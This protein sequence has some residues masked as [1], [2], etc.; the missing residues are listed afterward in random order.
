M[1]NPVHWAWDDRGM[2]ATQMDIRQPSQLVAVAEHSADAG[3]IIRVIGTDSTNRELRSQTKEGIGLDGILVPIHAQ[4]DFPYG[5]IAPDGVTIVTRST[6]T[7]PFVDFFTVN[8]EAHQFISGVQAVLTHIGTIPSGLTDKQKYYIGAIVDN[9][10]SSTTIRLYNT[11]IDAKTA[12]NPI[13]MQS[14]LDSITITLTDKRPI[15]MVTAVS[16]PGGIPPIEIA[17]ANQV[18]FARRDGSNI[19]TMLIYAVGD[20][21]SLLES[22]VANFE[23]GSSSVNL[24][25]YPLEVYPGWGPSEIKINL[26]GSVNNNTEVSGFSATSSS[27]SSFD[28][29]VDLIG[30]EAN[31]IV[32]LTFVT[33]APGFDLRWQKVES[34]LLP[35]P[36]EE[37]VAYFV[38]Q[39]DS[40]SVNDVALKVY[41][42]LNDAQSDINEIT[43]TGTNGSTNIFIRK[44]LSPQTK[45]VFSADPGYATGDTVTASTNGG[46]L[47]Q[48]LIAG[49]N[50]Y[51]SV[52]DETPV[53][54]MLHE[55]Y[56]DA[57]AGLNPISLTT[58]GT[59]QNSIAR[60]LPATASSG[61]R[62]NISVSGLNLPSASG[63]GAVVIPQVT[64]P[65]TTM[66]IVATGGGYSS[67]TCT[68]SDVGGYKY[69][70]TPTVLLQNGSYIV[71]ATIN[72][73]IATDPG[74][75][76]GYVSSL[77]VADGGQGYD[78]SNPPTVV[79]SGGL[80]SGGFV[81]NASVTIGR[82]I[83]KG[84]YNSLTLGQ[85]L[86][87][88]QQLVFS[89]TIV[90]GSG[91]M[92]YITTPSVSNP[93][94]GNTITSGTVSGGTGTLTFSSAH[95]LNS[96]DSIT[97]S[98]FTPA[99]WNT[100]FFVLSVVS[101]TQITVSSAALGA[102][103]GYG[104]YTFAKFSQYQIVR[105]GS[106]Y[107]APSI[108]GVLLNPN[109]IQ[110]SGVTGTV[111]ISSIKVFS[112]G[113]TIGTELLA[114]SLT[115][116]TTAAGATTAI[117]NA[118]NA[119]TSNSRFHATSSG[120]T[121]YATPCLSLNITSVGNVGSNISSLTYTTVANSGANSGAVSSPIELFA[122]PYVL[123]A[124]DSTPAAL[125]TSIAAKINANTVATQFSAV[126]VG[127]LVLIKPTFNVFCNSLVMTTNGSTTYF[128]TSSPSVT[129]TVVTVT[130]GVLTL[131]GI[132]LSP[133][134]PPITTTG[135]V[136]GVALLPYGS[137]ATASI[138]VNSI[139]G[140]VNGVSITQ[141][142]TGYLYPPRVSITAP[143]QLNAQLQVIAAG[144]G[145]AT[146][147]AISVRTSTGATITNILSGT[148]TNG[149]SPSVT[150]VASG[151]AGLITANG[152]TAAVSGTANDTIIVY[153]P[154]GISIASFSVTT[155]G[156]SP[157]IQLQS[158]IPIQATASS[159]ITTS[160][161]TGYKVA[162]SG[163]GYT[164]AP[165]INI[166]SGGGSGATATAVIDRYG[167]GSITVIK[168]GAGYPANLLCAISDSAGGTGTG[169][170]ANVVVS[171]GTIVAV[172]MTNF[173]RGYSAPAITF[174]DPAG[175]TLPS[176][177]NAAV[178][179]FSYTGVVTNVNVVT[180]G[181]GY[182]FTPTATVTPS[183]GVFVSFTS[184][185]VL[186][187]PLVQGQT[188]RA[189]NPSS[190][191]GFTLKGTD[192]S[193]INLT[194]TGSGNL[195][196][197]LSRSF[198][199]GF[200]GLWNGNFGGTFTG[201]TAW[202]RLQ[203][204][205]QLPITEP[206]T[207]DVTNYYITKIN[208]GSAKIYKDYARTIQIIPTQLGVGQSYY[209]I[210]CRAVGIVYNNW[211]RPN[212]G[213][214]L[215]SGMRIRFSSLD[216]VLPDPLVSTADYSLI[217]DGPNMSVSQIGSIVGMSLSGGGAL[218]TF[219][220][221]HSVSVGTTVTFSGCLPLQWNT[222]FIVAS[223]PSPNQILVYQGAIP[224]M[225]A[226]GTYTSNAVL[227]ITSLG[228]GNVSME[229]S[230]DFIAAAQTEFESQNCV[231]ETGDEISVRPSPGDSLPYPL[232]QSSL[233]NPASYFVRKTKVNSFELYETKDDAI[234][235]DPYGLIVLGTT[236]NTV[237][238]YFFCDLVR[239]P[240]LVKSIA[241]V[242][243]PETIGYV[244]LY[245][246]D[247]GRSNDM[248]LI[249][250]YHPSE[251]NPKYRR[252]RLGKPCAWARV[253]YRVSSPNFTSEYDYIPLESPRA[254]LAAVH[255]IDLEDK[256][257]M[258]Q[259]QK[260]WQVA[261]TYLKNENDSMDGHA[262]QPPQINN[263]T[264][265]DGTDPV[266]F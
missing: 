45:L 247:Y 181:T 149:A 251:T 101:P 206:A 204:D 25:G 224:M 222:S 43:L 185:G 51:V 81:P 142:G 97:L 14:I 26:F 169:A 54:V 91:A 243:K 21:G 95:G 256:D 42:T 161:I 154:A 132:I 28:N 151:V 12:T 190:G 110:I 36:L 202:V 236:G 53:A 188:Y 77:T 218:L 129:S 41:K 102:M 146:I 263:I 155:G 221:D 100:T 93:A 134:F 137:G 201:S 120:T 29:A 63:T 265:G 159:T 32:S 173:G 86:V 178:I 49:Q 148:F 75:N 184:T 57:I 234:N 215:A 196:L 125:A 60:L 4:S 228:H 106:G 119:N 220:A 226:Y 262:M 56:S 207:D 70:G 199:I 177:L 64:G 242:E 67:A 34:G 233:I 124:G 90:G 113:A 71:P 109:P 219:S 37:N 48:P 73:T 235:A 84:T 138:S 15:N 116:I 212:T 20:E 200:T 211:F 261:V 68:I 141:T 19:I 1:Y 9:V 179:E 35:N 24:L 174:I 46:T 198:S 223:I 175:G 237:E 156:P 165:A 55:T 255:A 123:V 69:V 150:A 238:S 89:D 186:P 171:N 47:P 31:A 195:F 248:A 216:E 62:N 176:G 8:N 74:T 257:F 128:A 30:P 88:G 260:Y 27:Y 78:A 114:S 241:H 168:G 133:V 157:A 147:T 98:G 210:G 17:V 240:T 213:Q 227:Q 6:T 23:D 118:I 167:I 79:F 107:S 194:S 183:T 39:V 193:D 254:I 16:L 135:V 83:P 145:S 205:Y 189:E 87:V 208:S 10:L 50:Y 108:V 111:S 82:G 96:G 103:T 214:Y 152:Y 166:S 249:G 162:S 231:F 76:L 52:L 245:A 250:Q 112:S 172:T 72:A 104:T 139:S 246:F 197:V 230:R 191:S 180:E 158:S 66:S 117:A 13:R 259:A 122:S 170:S 94:A 115:G 3:K 244:S 225:T 217:V 130:A 232:A 127:S 2:V 143:N 160:F 105:S 131:A 92:G 140:A 164:T 22:I 58:T 85:N 192:F 253:L 153:A 136:S 65:I 59:G 33:S 203:S 229:M 187:S 38:R 182:T 239:P 11:E 99:G 40:G 258:E 266:M 163:K 126:A 121:V 7:F 209:A 144:A 264:F 61:T 252:I 44:E 5:T 80:A 18:T